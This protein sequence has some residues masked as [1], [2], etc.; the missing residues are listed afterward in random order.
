MDHPK[1]IETERSE[2]H[3]LYK[4]SWRDLWVRFFTLMILCYVT[5]VIFLSVTLISLPAIIYDD[6]NNDS[7]V[8]LSDLIDL[9]R[10]EGLDSILLSSSFAFLAFSVSVNL[11]FIFSSSLKGR[12]SVDLFSVAVWKEFLILLMYVA[13]WVLSCF[14]LTLWLSANSPR[15]FVSALVVTVISLF[16]LGLSSAVSNIGLEGFYESLYRD[17]LL[18]KRKYADSI[19]SLISSTRIYLDWGSYSVF[20]RLFFLVR[21]VVRIFFFSLTTSSI[22]F[23]LLV[24]LSGGSVATL[25]NFLDSQFLSLVAIFVS[26]VISLYILSKPRRNWFLYGLVIFLFYVLILVQSIAFS[27]PRG[28]FSFSSLFSVVPTSA[29]FFLLIS[30]GSIFTFFGFLSSGK[31]RS[32]FGKFFLFDAWWCVVYDR[33]KER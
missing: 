15:Q 25:N 26:F 14:V 20:H 4:K 13:S 19:Y 3:I 17:H 18:E 23:S 22:L 33:L 21:S 24:L 32:L 7:L 12:D 10:G 9:L 27:L 30:L 28:K 6:V 1:I 16:V 8:D 2:S 29:T 31:I 5:S 11:G